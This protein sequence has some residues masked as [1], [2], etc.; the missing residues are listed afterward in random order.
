MDQF[1]VYENSNA[2]TKKLYPY[3]VDIQHAVISELSTRIVI[4][5]GDYLQLEKVV[6]SRLSPEIN[7]N[8]QRLVLLTPQLSAVPIGILKTQ[9]GSLKN[10]RDEIIAS[11]DFAITGV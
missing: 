7:F 4:P 5:L 9:V 6:M 8:G 10:F 2:K 3:L 11:L 1:D